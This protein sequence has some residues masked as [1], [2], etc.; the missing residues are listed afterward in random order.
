MERRS[1]AIHLYTVRLPAGKA[2]SPPNWIYAPTFYRKRAE[3]K[4]TVRGLYSAY[5]AAGSSKSP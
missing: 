1:F 3:I 2:S 4:H 5:F